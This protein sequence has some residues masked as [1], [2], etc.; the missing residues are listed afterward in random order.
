MSDENQH[1]QQSINQ[2]LE[3]ENQGPEIV[4]GSGGGKKKKVVGSLAVLAALGIGGYLAVDKYMFEQ[5]NKEFEKQSPAAIADAF[6]SH[7]GEIAKAEKVLNAIHEVV[8]APD[9]PETEEHPVAQAVNAKG[10]PV[11]WK[12]DIVDGARPVFGSADQA[13]RLRDLLAWCDDH[14]AADFTEDASEEIDSRIAPFSGP[15]V[16]V[17]DFIELKE[18][19]IADFNPKAASASYN[20]GQTRCA[21]ALFDTDS[22]TVI[23]HGVA[24]ATNSDN[25]EANV[26]ELIEDLWANTQKAIEA[27][28][29]QLASP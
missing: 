18:P 10:A 7:E 3:P 20:S 5:S 1:A 14:D 17:A 26:S 11:L 6:K 13:A 19:E 23:A 24:T 2:Q 27:K 29:D 4:S 25:I 21:V 28:I 22:L 16:A 9:W 8:N 12:Y 15:I